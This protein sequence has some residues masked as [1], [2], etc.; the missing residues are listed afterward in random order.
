VVSTSPAATFEDALGWSSLFADPYP[1]YRRMR[2]EQPVYWS[3]RFNSWLVTR[4]DD[5]VGALR[6]RRLSGRRTSTFIDQQLDPSM[7]E[8]VAPLKRQLE[9]FIGFTDPPDHTRLRKLVTTAFTWRV[10]EAARPRIQTIVDELIDAVVERGTLDLIRDV[11]FPAPAI[12]IAEFLGVPAADRH[13]F[14]RWADDFVPFITSG[15]LT[16][17]IAQTAQAGLDAMRAYLVDIVEER[18]RAPRQDLLSH[19]IAAEDQGDTLSDDELLSLCM[20]ML[21]GGHETTTNLIGNG[22]LALLRHPDQAERLRQDASLLPGA[23]EEV[24]RFD[25]PLQRTF[26]VATEDFELGGQTVQR[27]Q[28]V[29]MLLGAANRDPRRFDAPDTLDIAR[30]DNH[31]VAFGQGIHACFGSPLAR[32]EGEIAFGTILRRLPGLRLATDSLDYQPTVGLRAL[33]ALPL[34]FDPPQPAGAL[35]VNA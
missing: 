34:E 6:D 15:K 11:A 12:V 32:L 29:A 19:L 9:S 21:I 14:K 28:I 31:H 23:V 8:R 24:L 17:E 22:T 18:R 33:K 16:I 10:A 4:Y 35:A 7:R 1:L 3:D 30:P 27:G 5:V 25:S 26:R 13:R 20:T 2:D